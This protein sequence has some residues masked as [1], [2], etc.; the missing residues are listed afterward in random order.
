MTEACTQY[1]DDGRRI[2]D[3]IKS[4]I[5]EHI[6]KMEEITEKKFD[7]KENPLLV[8]VRS[9]V[10]PWF[11]SWHR[12]VCLIGVTSLIFNAK[13]N[14][15]G[16]FL[17]V[18]FSLLYGIISVTFFYY[19]EMLTYLGITM[20]MAA[21]ALISWLRSPNNGNK[22]EEKVNTLHKKEIVFM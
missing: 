3:E 16:Q 19:G 11:S 21:F 1:Y 14:I 22:A 8:S 10:R 17:M 7:D 18:I 13:G 12:S 2:N 15:L 4:Q 6:G 9:G 5:M 20:P